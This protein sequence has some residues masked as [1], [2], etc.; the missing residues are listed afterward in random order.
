M[1]IL[2]GTLLD[3]ND[4]IRYSG[5]HQRTRK[6]T[7]ANSIKQHNAIEAN[8]IKQHNALEANLI[9]S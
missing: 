5:L 8:S 6:Q 3:A 9:T 7:K 4:K 2:M 1:G